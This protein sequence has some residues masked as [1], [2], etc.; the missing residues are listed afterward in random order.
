[1]SEV[2]IDRVVFEQ[3]LMSARVSLLTDGTHDITVSVLGG[4]KCSF[5]AGDEQDAKAI[6]STLETHYLD[7]L[8]KVQAAVI[9]QFANAEDSTVESP[10]SQ[11]QS[12]K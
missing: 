8:G 12:S 5:T 6:Y 3:P 1:M 2:A 9:T 10:S 7:A 11:P 4:A